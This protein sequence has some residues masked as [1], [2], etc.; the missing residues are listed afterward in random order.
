MEDGDYAT[1]PSRAKYTFRP[2]IS[3]Q[4]KQ[5]DI[6]PEDPDEHFLHTI[7]TRLG[8]AMK[9]FSQGDTRAAVILIRQTYRDT[10]GHDARA[11]RGSYVPVVG[12]AKAILRLQLAIGLSKVTRHRQALEEARGAKA[13]MDDFWK[14]AFQGRMDAEE[15]SMTGDT[16]KP[17]PPMK[18][19]LNNPPSWLPRAVEVTVQTRQCVALESEFVGPLQDTEEARAE[20]RAE[21]ERLHQEAVDSATQLLGE[22][23]PVRTRARRGLEEA[24]ARASKVANPEGRVR[25]SVTADLGRSLTMSG[26]SDALRLTDTQLEYS[27]TVDEPSALSASSRL[28]ALP[29]EQTMEPQE[30]AARF[31]GVVNEAMDRAG[32]R[33]RRPVVK[34]GQAAKANETQDQVPEEEDAPEDTPPDIDWRRRMVRGINKARTKRMMLQEQGQSTLGVDLLADCF[35]Q[36][37]RKN[38]INPFDDWKVNVVGENTTTYTGMMLQD[39]SGFNKLTTQLRHNKAVYKTLK[40]KETPADEL[41]ELRVFYSDAGAKSITMRMER[42]KEMQRDPEAEAAMAKREQELLQAHGIKSRAY[43]RR[44]QSTSSLE[45]TRLLMS[46]S[47]RR[48]RVRLGLE[49]ERPRRKSL[50]IQAAEDLRALVANNED[51]GLGLFKSAANAAANP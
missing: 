47:V 16:S 28:S 2:D 5:A 32:I 29:A 43:N 30:A 18:R 45:R 37:R 15:A 49:V 35:Q 22:G 26:P 24:Q 50:A 34:G 25:R 6:G 19:M 13:E 46:E 1:Y 7:D 9:K 27:E 33:G 20:W 4:Q 11:A 17:A 31:K 36:P 40:I 12:L 48:E 42:K 10:E 41:A 39:P 8:V 51:G 44:S 38:T 3:E 21:L 23:D 14:A